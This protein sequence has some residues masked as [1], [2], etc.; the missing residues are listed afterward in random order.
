MEKDYKSFIHDTINL[1]EIRLMLGDALGPVVEE[2]TL[3]PDMKQVNSEEPASEETELANDRVPAEEIF[4][5][6]I[7]SELP[8][9]K[10][11][12]EDTEEEDPVEVLAVEESSEE[13]SSFEFDPVLAAETMVIPL[14][15]LEIAED[16]DSVDVPSFMLEEDEISETETVLPEEP[17]AEVG[18]DAADEDTQGD[19]S[20]QKPKK[21]LAAAHE[22]Y[23]LLHDVVYLLAAVTLIF[24]FLVRLVGVK[25]DSM[26]PTLWNQDYLLLESN[27][28]YR[29]DDI[30]Y[31]DIVVLNVPYYEEQ[32][33]GPIVKRVIATEGQTVQ[34]D[35]DSG[36]VYVDGVMLTE[37]YILEPTTYNWQ[38]ELGMQ[39]PAVVPEN[40]IFVLG[41]NRNNSMDSRFASIG[42]IDERCVLGKVLFIAMPGQVEDEFGNVITPRDWGRIG[43]VS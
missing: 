16:D 19:E 40:C 29:G 4:Q 43:L 24:V 28:L 20:R 3:F 42:M 35:F 39:Y 13:E 38:G 21:K 34:I 12:A 6:E 30:Q 31:G 18:T 9:E 25:G 10:I 41:D 27:F 15:E 11:S 7:F 33:E 32:N 23:C 26:M 22:L 36:A 37:T 8:E 14:A 17:A 2:S 5:E 1:D